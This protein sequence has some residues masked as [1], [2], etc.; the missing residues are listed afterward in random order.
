MSAVVALAS[1]FRKV[2]DHCDS[3]ACGDDA[4]FDL[5]VDRA[6]KLSSIACCAN[7]PMST[8]SFTSARHRRDD[9]FSEDH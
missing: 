7:V 4:E 1:L 9:N 5:K 6:A 3:A 2:A 8:E